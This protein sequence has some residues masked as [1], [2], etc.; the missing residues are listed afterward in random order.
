MP[1]EGNCRGGGHPGTRPGYY[2][3]I[4]AN[5]T[6]EI[7]GSAILFQMEFIKYW[8]VVVVAVAFAS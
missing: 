6:L 1:R 4:V 8:C 2:M 7:F 3:S 5:V